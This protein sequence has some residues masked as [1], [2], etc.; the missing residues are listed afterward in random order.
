MLVLLNDIAPQYKSEGL[1]DYILVRLAS[2]D[3]ACHDAVGT[4]DF[5]HDGSCRR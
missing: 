4:L 5:I 1:N 2:R 3:Y